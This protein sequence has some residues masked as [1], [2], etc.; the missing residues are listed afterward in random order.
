[1][2]LR[3]R[4]AT[5]DPRVYMQEFE[6]SFQALAGRVYANFNRALDV[7]LVG[8]PMGVSVAL[9]HLPFFFIPD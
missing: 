4:P 7:G 2:R 3:D 8:D 9:W 5:L 6:A 1:M